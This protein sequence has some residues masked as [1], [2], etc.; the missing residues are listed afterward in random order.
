MPLASKS[1]KAEPEIVINFPQKYYVIGADLSLKRPGF[2]KLTV[3]KT[4]EGTRFTDIQLMSVDNKTDSKKPH[5]QL[6]NEIM[7]AFTAFIPDPEKDQTPC[8]YIRETEIISKHTP[9]ERNISKVVGI[10][11]WLLW[12][13]NVSWQSLYP[14]SIKKLVAGS[15]KA[16][17]S[18]VAEHLPYYVGEIKYN[19]DDESDATA[20]AIAWLLQQNQL[21]P[22]PIVKS[23]EQSG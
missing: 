21:Q 12:R 19:N 5:G 22:Q 2:C 7:E 1:K 17:K 20:V 11:D 6:L 4:E 3:E 23:G 15:G 16:D 14:V 18:A 10:M 9:Y 13:L 8:F